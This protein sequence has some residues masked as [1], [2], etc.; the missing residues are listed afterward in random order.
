MPVLDG[1]GFG[2]WS[3]IIRGL[4]FVYNTRKKTIIN[5]SLSGPAN[6]AI[7]QT[8]HF[9]AIRGWKMIVA[10]G[11]SGQDAC[12]FSP[13]RVSSVVTIGAYDEARYVSRFSNRGR[14]VDIYGPGESIAST[15]PNNQYAILSGTSMASPIVAGMLSTNSSLTLYE[16]MK[17]Y[18]QFDMLSGL[19]EDSF[20][21]K[22]ALP[23][24][25][26]CKLKLNPF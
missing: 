16:F 3:T 11:N 22:S 24:S 13:A 19:N 20:N 17:F 23:H 15:F 8:V 26:D 7:D 6:R 2:L 9:M 14:C 12:N 4:E 25:E 10:A 5:M 21:I 18:T 1:Q